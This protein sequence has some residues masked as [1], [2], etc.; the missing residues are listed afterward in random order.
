MAASGTLTEV[1]SLASLSFC[2]WTFGRFSRWL[3]MFIQEQ[4]GERK[5]KHV[6][7][8]RWDLSNY[9]HAGKNWPMPLHISQDIWGE[10]NW[11]P[12]RQQQREEKQSVY[13]EDTC[14]CSLSSS[15]YISRWGNFSLL[16]SPDPSLGSVEGIVMGPQT[17]VPASQFVL[18]IDA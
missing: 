13:V 4:R 2:F 6:A 12:V 17:S 7:K 10:K 9:W 15:K 8:G 3:G 1:C 14:F 18:K 5:K 16:S 11:K